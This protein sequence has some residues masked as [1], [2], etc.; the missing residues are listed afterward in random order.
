MCERTR[1]PETLPDLE[2]LYI[3]H[4]VAA[5]QEEPEEISVREHRRV[6]EEETCAVYEPVPSTVTVPSPSLNILKL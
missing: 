6:S 4:G 1:N 3:R 5:D 2:Q